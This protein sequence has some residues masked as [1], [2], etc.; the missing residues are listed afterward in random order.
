M[1]QYVFTIPDNLQ[2]KELL[3]FILKTNIFKVK[4]I[5][6]DFWEELPENVKVSINK[7]IKQAKNGQLTPHNEVMQ[8]VKAKYLQ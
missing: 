6:K 5:K 3:N 1:Q 7:G 8:N 4:E 2:A